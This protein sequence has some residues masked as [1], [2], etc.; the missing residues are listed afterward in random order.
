[1]NASKE[2]VLSAIIYFSY[3]P[4]IFW[5]VLSL[6]KSILQKFPFYF[7]YFRYFVEQACQRRF[8]VNLLP[9]N[10]QLY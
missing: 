6:F 7:S 8:Q 3:N 9:E 1:M 10:P 2:S 5:R 4:R